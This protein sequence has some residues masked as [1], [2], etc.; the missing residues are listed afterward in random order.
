M[1]DKQFIAALRENSILVCRAWGYNLISGNEMKNCAPDQK[2]HNWPIRLYKMAKSLELF[3]QM[4]LHT[5]A[6]KYGISL[7]EKGHRFVYRRDLSEYF[8]KMA[9]RGN[10]EKVEQEEVKMEEKK[11]VGMMEKTLQLKKGEKREAGT[12]R[13]IS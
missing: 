7:I 11:P 8:Q 12:K 4:D 9:K 10:K 2:W 3:Q 6:I 13:E 5:N 1:K